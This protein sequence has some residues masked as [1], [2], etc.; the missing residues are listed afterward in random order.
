MEA[1]RNRVISVT[2]RCE[3][4]MGVCVVFGFTLPFVCVTISKVNFLGV[5]FL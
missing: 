3:Q 5:L 2:I 1:K 4:I